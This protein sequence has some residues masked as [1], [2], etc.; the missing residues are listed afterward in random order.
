MRSCSIQILALH[1]GNGHMQKLTSCYLH[2]STWRR[3]KL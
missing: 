3:K 2:L 1:S